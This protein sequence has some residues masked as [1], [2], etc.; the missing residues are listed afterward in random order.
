M[1]SLSAQE[2]IQKLASDAAFRSEIGVS[3]STMD[4]EAFRDKAAAAGYNYTPEEILAAAEAQQDSAL[5]DE[6][7]ENVSGG[8]ARREIS[9]SITIK[10]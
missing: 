5:S 3:S 6:A 1:S 2:F 10:F 9:I 4:L 7:L 8:V